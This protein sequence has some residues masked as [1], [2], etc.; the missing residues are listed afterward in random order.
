MVQRI[1]DGLRVVEAQKQTGRILQVGSQRTSSIVYEKAQELLAAGA[2]GELNLVEAWWNRN[3]AIGAWQ[4]S[5]PSRRLARDRRLGSLPGPR[6]QAAVRA[7]PPLPLAELRGLRH[8]RRRRPVRPPL[9]RHPLHHRRARARRGCMATGGLRYW[10]DGRDARRR[11]A[12][13]LRLPEDRQPSGVHARRC[14]V[15][16]ADGGGGGEEGFRF[17]GPEGAM[18]S[19]WAATGSRSRGRPAREGAR[20]HDRHLPEGRAGLLSSRSTGRSTPRRTREVQTTRRT[21][22]SSRPATTATTATHLAELHRR[23]AHPEAR[24]PGRD[25]RLA[26]GRP[27]RAVERQLLSRS[28]RS[29]GTPRR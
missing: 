10:K 15:N 13:S 22:G 14:E 2:I 27:R 8:R 16:F 5:D 1:D 28:G 19:R 7:H 4:Y 26:G 23:G 6:P 17:V 3:S 11:D 20:L 25:L 21:S 12:R 18:S 29:G 24:V 9:L